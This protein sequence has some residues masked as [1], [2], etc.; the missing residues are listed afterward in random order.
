MAR[1]LATAIVFAFAF[2]LTFPG[3]LPGRILLPLDHPRDLGAWK[4]DPE[5][6]FEISNKI[7]SDPI[8]EY[9]AWDMEIRRLLANG[10]MPWR[11]RWAGDGA[12]LYANPETALLFPFTWP[13][14]LLGDRGWVLMA[15]LKLWAGGLGIWWFARLMGAEWRFAL[16]GS[17]AYMA[18]GYMTMWLLFP[19]TNVYATLPWLAGCAVQYLRAPSRRWALGVIATAA[20][21]TAGGHPETL[22]H[23]VIALALFLLFT[24]Q[25][26]R[27]AMAA[28]LAFA[29]F[30]LIAA[31][32]VPF[33]LALSKSDIVR[34]RSAAESHSV[35]IYA[36]IAQVLPGFLGS[37]LRGEIDLSGIAQPEAENFNERNAGYAGAITL[38]VLAFAWRRLSRELRIGLIIGA[39]SLIVGWKLPLV[40]DAI[41]AL[42]LFSVAAN[43]RFPL[44]FVFF[45]SAALPS[46][47][48]IVA[49]DVPRRKIGF[50]IAIVSIGLALAAATPAVPAGSDLLVRGARVGIA[51]MQ[52]R[53][54][55]RKSPS[56]YEDRLQHYLGGLRV[57]TLRRVAVPLLLIGVAGIALAHSRRRGMVIG[58]AVAAEMIVFAWGYAPAVHVDDAAKVP[59][60]IEAIRRLDPANQYLVAAS[61]SVYDANLGTIHRVRDLRSYDVLQEHGRIER[62]VS[63]GFDRN[64]RAFPAMLTSKA[65]T[66]MAG[67]GVRFFLTRYPPPAATFVAGLPSPAVG[68]YELP[69]AT[70]VPVPANL[71]P[72]GL[73]VGLLISAVALA[74][75]VALVLLVPHREP[76]GDML[77]T[78]S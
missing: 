44:V 17:A 74:V 49:A 9:L 30:A 38:I 46:A 78:S 16:V 39:A 35:R 23:G 33:A 8:Y 18:S 64:S 60:S 27:L 75:A 41:R 43:E 69:E 20:L 29:G 52:E 76:P 61:V 37:P 21:A 15:L 11:N 71:K 10:E 77:P 73:L 68:V 31:Q 47:L 34:T 26:R 58:A 67:E 70:P 24:G 40:D 51:R 7:V 5:S 32:L 45:A 12:H 22:F 72:E 56:Y 3:F 25:R 54:F 19:H 13:R 2:L 48:M 50:A 28:A 65:T 42:P 59:A 55:L 14:I 1:W 62:L 36:A 4:P 63:M 66:D 53:G 6:R 57:V